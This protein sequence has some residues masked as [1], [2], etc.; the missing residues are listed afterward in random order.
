MF[1]PEANRLCK[2]LEISAISLELA[3]RGG[4]QGKQGYLR[5]LSGGISRKKEAGFHPLK[6]KNRHEPKW[7]VVR[8]SYLLATEGPDQVPFLYVTP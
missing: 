6:F 4:I 3:N 2:F 7:F 8:E 5:V 1:K